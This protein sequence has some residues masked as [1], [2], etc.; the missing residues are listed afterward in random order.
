MAAHEDTNDTNKTSLVTLTGDEF[1]SLS[2]RKFR[3][4]VK[5]SV[6]LVID[7]EYM[8]VHIFEY[9]PFLDESSWLQVICNVRP[10]NKRTPYFL[11]NN[12]FFYR[13][14]LDNKRFIHLKNEFFMKNAV[15]FCIA[16]YKTTII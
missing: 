13:I 1:N 3:K 2:C 7:Y 4:L 11:R 10:L 9:S 8:Y 14:L 12:F 6:G 15:K 5:A 16:H